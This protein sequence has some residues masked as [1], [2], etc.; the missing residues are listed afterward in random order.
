MNIKNGRSAPVNIVVLDGYT[1]NPGDLSWQELER[2]GDL[3]VYDRTPE[4]LIYERAKDAEVLLTNKTP[5]RENVL[6]KLEKLKYI[7]VTAT[8]Y[9][10]VDI[11]YACDNNILVTNIPTYGTASVAQAVFALLLEMCNNVQKH[12]DLVKGGAWSESL[13]WCFWKYPLMELANKK[14]G[15]IGFGRIGQQTAKVANAL[16]MEVLA[17]DRFKLENLPIDFKYVELDQ[18]FAQADVIS[19][20]CPLTPE[21]TGIINKDTIAQM[22]RNVILINTSRGKLVVEDDLYEALS[23]GRIAGACLDVLAV[24]PPSRDNP[25]LK[26][27]NCII[28]PHISW[29]TKEARA[30]IM[31][32]TIEN[33]KAYLDNKP[34]NRIKLS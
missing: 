12:N 3:T 29:A 27:K 2:H 22:K 11:K 8:G 10:I 30:R 26:A 4:E 23:T 1:L 33:L 24:E 5:L 15:I 28:T 14:M 20:H 16:G 21:N 18:L 34:I 6:T 13:D 31:A 25:L 17:Y 19:L 9:D 32:L 7:S